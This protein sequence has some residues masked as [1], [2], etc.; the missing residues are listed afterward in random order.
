MNVLLTRTAAAG[1]T[2]LSLTL[3]ISPSPLHPGEEA[4]VTA[5]ATTP[6]T[7]IPSGGVRIDA[8]GSFVGFAGWSEHR[9]SL[10][11]TQFSVGNHTIVATYAGDDVFAGD[12]RSRP[13]R[14]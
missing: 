13:A 3:N 7:F 12:V 5:T 9:A 8:D 11:W 14:R 4:T 1:T 2:P 10:H 6:S